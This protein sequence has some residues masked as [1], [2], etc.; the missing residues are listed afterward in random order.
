M[1]IAVAEAVCSFLQDNR[2][3]GVL[4]C[5]ALS[6]LLLWPHLQAAEPVLHPLVACTPHHLATAQCGQPEGEQ[7]LLN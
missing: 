5:W 2:G 6:A 1:C 7:P 4:P 3:P